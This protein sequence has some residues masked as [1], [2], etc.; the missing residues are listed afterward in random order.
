MKAL[1]IHEHGGPDVAR[2]DPDF[3]DPVANEGDVI[4]RVGATSLNYHDVFTRNGMPGI[5]LNF[6]I[7]MGLD[8]AGE[9]VEVGPGVQG[10]SVGDRVLVDPINRAEGGLVGETVHGGLAQLCRVREHQL[11]R[12]PDE[13]SFEQAAALPVAFGTAYR[14]IHTIGQVQAGDKVLVLG[15]SG[16]VGVASVL[17]AK[18]AGAQV[19]ACASSAAKLAALQAL[20]ADHVIDYTTT[21]FVK[22]IWQRYGKP[23]RRSFDGGVDV[24]VNFT[25]GDTWVKSMKTLRRGAR[26]LT[27][28]ATAGY[29]PQT[30]LRFVWTYELSIRGSNGWMREDLQALLALVATGRLAVPIDRVLPLERTGEGLALIEQRQVIGK[31]VVQP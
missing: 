21:D 8:V 15:A 6:P 10:W 24:A 30:D 22:D 7:I 23:H 12:L 29:D 11:I 13:V 4:I 2:I 16:G 19:I 20:G 31:V 28:G 3:P 25:G 26:L 27:C 18:L 1:V 17:L 9:I 5:K 14:M